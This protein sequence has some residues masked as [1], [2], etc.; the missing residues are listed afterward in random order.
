MS[1]IFQTTYLL[2]FMGAAVAAQEKTAVPVPV[3]TAPGVGCY[4][5]ICAVVRETGQTIYVDLNSNEVAPQ[6]SSVNGKPPYGISCE[7]SE[8]CLIVDSVGHTW[9]GGLRPPH[10]WQA[11]PTLP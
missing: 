1:R 11:G 10:A 7:N 3:P 4:N 5:R 6:G 9:K 2:L 8:Y